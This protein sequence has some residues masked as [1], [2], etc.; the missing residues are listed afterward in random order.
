[1]VLNMS[2]E[3][4]IQLIKDRII[5]DATLK[6]KQIIKKAEEE[7]K[8]N[9][10]KFR[11]SLE[12]RNDELIQSAENEVNQII[13]RKKAE[14]NV[15]A[16]RSVLDKKEEMIEGVFDSAFEE[17]KKLVK[18]ESYN[19]FLEKAIYNSTIELG[20]GDIK[21]SK[22]KDTKI[23]NSVLKKIAAKATKELK[24]K[25]SI[26]LDKN[27]IN[28]S[29]GVIVKNNDGTIEINNSFEALLENAKTSLRPKI[30]ELLFT[31]KGE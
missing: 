14:A 9:L 3:Q 7:Y 12:A 24:V 28:C 26:D 16:K 11:K 18:T 30:A 19:K 25:T 15:Y 27:N 20:G 6:A 8:E 31:N 2:R 5:N 21:I 23:D 17:L 22:S 13:E 4:G 10:A 29:G 1:M